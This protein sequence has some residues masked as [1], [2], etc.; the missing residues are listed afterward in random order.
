MINKFDSILSRLHDARLYGFLLDIEPKNF[1]SNVLLYIHLFSD[2][3]LGKYSLEKGL[4]VF[5]NAS[6]EKLSIAN[7]LSS[8]QF[9]IID[10]IVNDLGNNKFRFSFTFNDPSIRLDLIAENIFI[11][12]S[13]L[14]EQKEEQFLATNW[15]NLLK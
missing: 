15:T 5:E 8:G 11:K 2:F 4:L 6:I 10:C 9:Y 12:S 13:G 3:D 1:T 14:V 7:D